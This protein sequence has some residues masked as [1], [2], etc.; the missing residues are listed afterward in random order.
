RFEIELPLLN[1]KSVS[2][3]DLYNSSDIMVANADFIRCRQLSLN[4]QFGPSVLRKLHV[5]NLSTAFSLT[6]P[7]LIAFD[8]AWR[9]YDPETAGWPARRVTS[10]SLNMTF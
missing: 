8:K 3:Y 1:P 7:F 4:Y 9:G 2:P 5:R 10:V 6:N